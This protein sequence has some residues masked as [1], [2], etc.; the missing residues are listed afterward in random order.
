[1]LTIAKATP[2][3]I[4]QLRDMIRKLCAFHGDPCH[5]GLEE[6]QVRFI[7]GPLLA[8]I[9]HQDGLS[10]GYAVLQTHW[11]PA[12][13]GDS[14]DVAHLFVE[15]AMRGRGIGRQLIKAAIGIAHDHHASRL[16]I[17]TSPNNPS[18]AAAYRAMGLD[19]ITKPQGARFS[20]PL[21]PHRK[22]GL[23]PSTP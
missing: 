8:L 23:D 4:A 22:M 13:H 20:I 21:S 5:L 2:K 3:D 12:A 19:E 6:A 1:M 10:V 17:G 9:A 11:R 18:A 7:N 16:T 14:L 15:E